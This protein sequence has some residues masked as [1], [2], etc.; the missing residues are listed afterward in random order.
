MLLSGEAVTADFYRQVTEEMFGN[1]PMREDQSPD[2]LLLHTAGQ[3]DDGFYVYDVWESKE[4]FER[5]V[6]SKLGP[7]IGRLDAG[8]GGRPEP[9]FFPVDQLVKGRALCG[10]GGARRAGPPPEIIGRCRGSCS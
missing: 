3:G 6:Q 8:G 1:F 4:H 9:Q 2:G 5:F 7:A 10:R